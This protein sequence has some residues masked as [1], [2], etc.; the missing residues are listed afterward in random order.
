MK[1]NNYPKFATAFVFAT[2]LTFSSV[3]SLRITNS[4]VAW[5]DDVPGSD[6]KAPS[7][8]SRKKNPVAADDKSLAAGKVVYFKQCLSCHGEQGHGDGPAS[9]DL[10]PKPHNLADPNISAQ[11]DG[12][13]FWKI[14][15]GKKPMPA[16]ESLIPE[17]DRWNVINYVRTLEPKPATQPDA[18]KN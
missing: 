12:S 15:T 13:M 5:A 1:R 6:W 17:N 9:K 18:P 2:F 3:L 16:F 4:G 10:N 7:R 14:T 8:D 11:T